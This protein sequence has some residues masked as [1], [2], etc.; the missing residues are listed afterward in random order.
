MSEIEKDRKRFSGMTGAQIERIKAQERGKVSS[1]HSIPLTE[2]EYDDFEEIL[3]NITLCKEDIK[4]AMGFAYDKIESAEEVS[5]HVIIWAYEHF[6]CVLFNFILCPFCVVMLLLYQIVTLLKESLL[7]S[8]TPPAVK[9]ARLYVLS[10][11]LHNSSAAIKYA[12]NY[13]FVPV[14]VIFL[15]CTRSLTVRVLNRN[16]RMLIQG[17]LPEIFESMGNIKRSGEGLGRM[18]SL[19]VSIVLNNKF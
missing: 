2:D 5:C 19:V 1:L 13:R 10:D 11:I 3:Q 6:D 9:M 4:V 12:T 7:L 8:S 14:Y 18:I 15:Y 16:I 17:C